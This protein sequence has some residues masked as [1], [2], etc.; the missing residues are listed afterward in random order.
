MALPPSTAADATTRRRVIGSCNSATAPSAAITG[1]LTARSAARV[2]VRKGRPRTRWRSQAGEDDTGE[3]GIAHARGVQPRPRQRRE[4]QGKR[5][6]GSRAGNCPRAAAGCG[7]AP[8]KQGIDAPDNA[9]SEHQPRSRRAR[10]PRGPAIQGAPAGPA[11]ARA[12]RFGASRSRSP[13]TALRISSTPCTAPQKQ[14]R[15]CAGG[16]AERSR[17]CGDREGEQRQPRSASCRPSAASPGL[18][19]RTTSHSASVPEARRIA[20]KACRVDIRAREGPAAQHGNRRAGDQREPVSV[21]SRSGLGEGALRCF[22]DAA[23]PPQACQ[24]STSAERSRAVPD[25]TGFCG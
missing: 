11:R 23:V 16:H 6:P 10:A 22:G 13:A 8:A 25:R 19:R 3:Q 18:C 4:A 1:V 20:V 24:T 14:Q 15:A 12:R 7:R 21:N 2:A 9:R 5:E 17:R